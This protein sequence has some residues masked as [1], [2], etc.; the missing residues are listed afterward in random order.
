M[1]DPRDRETR[2]ADTLTMLAAPRVSRHSPL[3][4][5]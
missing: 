3:S 4:M 5:T 2:K 1:V